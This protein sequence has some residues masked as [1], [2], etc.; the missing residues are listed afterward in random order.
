MSNDSFRLIYILLALN[1]FVQVRGK[2]FFTTKEIQITYWCTWNLLPFVLFD[3]KLDTDQPVISCHFLLS[4]SSSNLSFWHVSVLLLDNSLLQNK[5]LFLSNLKSFKIYIWTRSDARL[6]ISRLFSARNAG[7]CCILSC[8]LRPSFYLNIY[9]L[10][11][12]VSCI[13][14]I[15]DDQRAN[16]FLESKVKVIFVGSF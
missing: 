11:I 8:V 12:F 2:T 14:K 13:L 16:H 10:Q 6:C 4:W 7:A 15:C 9:Q 3:A 5:V 1:S